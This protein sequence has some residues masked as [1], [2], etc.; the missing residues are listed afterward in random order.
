MTLAT[1]MNLKYHGDLR[2]DR[3]T[4]VAPGGG[5]RRSGRCPRRSVRRARAAGR[6]ARTTARFRRS[7]SGPPPDR[8]PAPRRG[9]APIDRRLRG[10]WSPPPTPT[11]VGTLGPHSQ[12]D[13]SRTQVEAFPQTPLD[14]AEVGGLETTVGE[15]REGG[16]VVGPLHSVLDLGPDRRVRHLDRLEG[17]VELPGRDPRVVRLLRRSH[18]RQDVVDP[19]AGQRADPQYRGLTQVGQTVTHV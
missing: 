15:Q 16:R 8:A 19:E 2:C 7:P 6:T 14:I 11:P 3:G 5:S 1:R 4:G 17:P 10:G 9:S 18:R 13:G 12:F